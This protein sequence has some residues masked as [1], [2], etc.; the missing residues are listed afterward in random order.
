MEI[1]NAGN[2]VMNTYIYRAPSGWVM[3]DTGY[4]HS[5]ESVKRRLNRCGIAIEDIRY[6]FL[7]HAHDDH[8]GFLNELL[9]KYTDVRVIVS[10]KAIPVLLKGQNSFAGGCSGRLSLA[11][12]RLMTITGM[13]EHRFPAIEEKHLGR[14]IEISPENR[15]DLETLLGGKILVTQGH[16]ADS[17]SLKIGNIIFCGD[18]VMNGVPSINRVTIWIENKADYFNSWDILL[19]ESAEKL[20]PA[21]GKPFDSGELRKY[22]SC[23]SGVRLYTLH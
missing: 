8:A 10:D 15:D 21:H 16:T 23:A 5:L 3:I 13:G 7:T 12:C 18:A 14:L 1:Y 4:E 6:V 17:V 2:R 22:K 19:A 20:Y 11:F 9:S